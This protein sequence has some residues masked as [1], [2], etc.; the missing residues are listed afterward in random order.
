MKSVNIHDGLD[1]TLLILHSR[2]KAR[3]DR[4]AIQ[5]IKNY[6]SLPLVECYPGQLNQVFMNL[7]ANAIDALETGNWEEGTGQDCPQSPIPHHTE[8]A[9]APNFRTP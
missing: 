6:N 5:V 7:L 1:S 4:P 3:S 8:G 9:T 2:L